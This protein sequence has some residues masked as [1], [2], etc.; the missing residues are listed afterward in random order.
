MEIDDAKN[1]KHHPTKDITRIGM[2]TT[3]STYISLMSVAETFL[4]KLTYV[5]NSDGQ[6]LMET[7][8]EGKVKLEVEKSLVS[9]Q[10]KTVPLTV[11]C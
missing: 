1:S 2:T 11:V 7:T 3:I 10:K 5:S 9:H 4:E 6:I 8:T